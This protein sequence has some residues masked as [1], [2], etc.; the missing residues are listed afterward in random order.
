MT[1]PIKGVL[2]ASVTPLADGGDRVDD[3]GFAPLLDFY[4]SAGLDGVLAMGTTGE[5]ILL[6]TEERK[7][8]TDLFVRAA[9]GR[10]RVIA[11]AGAQTTAA[12]VEIAAHAAAAGA[13]GVAVI[14]PPYFPLDRRAIVDHF[15]AAASACAPLP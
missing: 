10:L 15:V 1:H 11:H 4:A 12:T 8:V 2:A 5:G 14:A 13:D 6:D 9:G 7:R 3:A